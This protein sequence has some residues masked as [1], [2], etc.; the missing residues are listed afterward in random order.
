MSIDMDLSM[1]YVETEGEACGLNGDLIEG[2]L[3]MEGTKPKGRG[4]YR[5]PE[6]VREA[7]IRDYEAGASILMLSEKYDAVWLT[8]RNI[9]TRAGVPIRRKAGELLKRNTKLF[10]KD[11]EGILEGYKSGRNSNELAETYGVTQTMISRIVKM[12][13][14]T[15]PN[16]EAHR[17]HSLDETVFDTVTEESAY[18]VGFLIT[19]GAIVENEGHSPAVKLGLQES[20]LGHLYKFRDF[21]KSGHRIAHKIS[22][23]GDKKYPSV[24]FGVRS[25]KLTSALAKFGVIP[26]KS[27]VAKVVGLEKDRH[28]WRG[29]IDGDGCIFLRETPG[30]LQLILS[31]SEDLTSQFREYVLSLSPTC[32]SEVH[33]D[34]SIFRLAITGKHAMRAIRE[35]YRD[36][37]VA[38]DRKAYIARWLME[39]PDYDDAVMEARSALYVP[40]EVPHGL[41]P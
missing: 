27:H 29:V 5:Y 35:L 7:I 20:D 32:G 11:R 38:L 30:R 41:A 39:D 18:W 17:E 34:K 40:K 16:E 10:P 6:E 4:W 26:R 1:R 23:E 14:L 2:G 33:P 36:A 12:A 22:D 9:L 24:H 25:G 13:G 3:S 19:D 37:R 8:V 21:L 31:G 15:R 28:F